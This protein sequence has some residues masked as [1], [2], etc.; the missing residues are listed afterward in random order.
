MTLTNDIH[1][2][3]AS[4][5]KV[6]QLCDANAKLLAKQQEQISGE[7]GLVQSV[8]TLRT[9]FATIRKGGYWLA[10]VIVAGSITFAFSVLA[11]IQ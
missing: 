10:G 4:V 7:G 6:E 1:A 2:L 9:E 3:R 11:L 5:E 8:R